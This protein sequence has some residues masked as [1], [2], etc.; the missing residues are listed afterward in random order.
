[1][2]KRLMSL[3]AALVM[4]MVVLPMT[5]IPVRAETVQS[6]DTVIDNP[7]EPDDSTSASDS[8]WKYVPVRPFT[9][10][11]SDWTQRLDGKLLTAGDL[12]SEQQ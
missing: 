3:L 11:D 10:A 12:R 2:Q 4:A 7:D 9:A 8:E 6:A 5:A 1:M